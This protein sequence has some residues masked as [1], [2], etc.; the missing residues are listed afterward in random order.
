MSQQ[1]GPDA[2]GSA[3]ERYFAYGSNLNEA[4]LRSRCPSSRVVC[5]ATLPRHTLAFGGHSRRWKG[6]VAT[7]VPAEEATVEGVL[8]EME[9]EDIEALDGFE[10]HPHTYTRVRR[11][12]SLTGGGTEDAYVYVL[13]GKTAPG[14]PS[15][16]YLVVLRLAY[17]ERRFDQAPLAAAA[18]A[19]LQALPAPGRSS[20]FVYGTLLLGEVNHHILRGARWIGP[21]RTEARYALHDLGEYPAI[22][23][24]GSSAVAGELYAVDAATLDAMDQLEGHPRFYRRLPVV[25]LGGLPAETYV[26]SPHRSTRYPSIAG[27]DWREH[28]RG[29]VDGPR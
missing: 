9:A 2:R 18:N 8:Y 24:G 23:E 6:A 19:G 20:V 14:R 10:G 4:R 29:R 15:G 25:L 12:V 11:T 1:P 27:G 7:V 16:E 3:I 13:P 26:I 17:L 21:A 28:R 22:V 5:S